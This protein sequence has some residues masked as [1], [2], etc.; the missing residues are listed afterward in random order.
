VDVGPLQRIQKVTAQLLRR[1]FLF[2]AFGQ[3]CI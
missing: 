3:F 1:R 2:D